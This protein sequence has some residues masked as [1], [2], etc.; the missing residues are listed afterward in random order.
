MNQARLGLATN[1]VALHMAKEVFLQDV[2]DAL[3]WA[4]PAVDAD[5]PSVNTDHLARVFRRAAI[6]LTPRTVAA[7]DPADFRDLPSDDRE[8]L[9]RAIKG[10]RR[11]SGTVPPDA[12]ASD[13]QVREG[14]SHL[15]TIARVIG[16]PV[17]SEWLEEINRLLDEVDSWCRARGWRTTRKPKQLEEVLLGSY[18][19][20]EL[21]IHTPE[22]MALLEPAARFASGTAGVFDL[23]VWPPLD[24]TTVV[25]IKG[26]WY[27]NPL[28]GGR[29]KR[30][31]EST[32][33]AI[34]EELIART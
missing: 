15:Q 17:L 6:W 32:F 31:S 28:D 30:W 21:V 29:R 34:T 13:E 19:A 26:V 14:W 10:F 16:K 27:V 18:E 5:S 12:P 24:S 8:T 11:V 25:C 2:R 3:S 7:F 9:H 1:G 4:A 22:K 33:L 20:T 23:S